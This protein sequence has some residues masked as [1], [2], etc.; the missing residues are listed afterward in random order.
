MA[1]GPDLS[2]QVLLT[3]MR[4]IGSTGDNGLPGMFVLV[5]RLDILGRKSCRLIIGLP[6]F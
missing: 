3:F 4:D 6:S 2:V 5:D 1:W